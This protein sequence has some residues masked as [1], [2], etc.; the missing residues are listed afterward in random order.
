M[1]TNLKILTQH[2]MRG[3]YAEAFCVLEK[4]P[5]TPQNMDKYV[6]IVNFTCHLFGVGNCHKPDSPEAAEV[7]DKL[8]TPIPQ[9]HPKLIHGLIEAVQVAVSTKTLA[10]LYLQKGAINPHNTEKE[11][12][13]LAWITFQRPP[14]HQEQLKQYFTFPQAAFWAFVREK[15]QEKH[16]FARS[17]ENLMPKFVGTFF[18]ERDKTALQKTVKRSGKKT[19]QKKL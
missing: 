15:G 9:N 13:E 16:G 5:P 11:M 4:N 3:Q 19:T 18:V 8:L 7:L 12:I 2:L 17:I 10:D 1:D 6:E 14:H